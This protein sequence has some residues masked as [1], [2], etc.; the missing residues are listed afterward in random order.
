M[1]VTHRHR[2]QIRLGRLYDDGYRDETSNRPFDA[3]GLTSDS[4]MANA[5]HLVVAGEIRAEE[6][7]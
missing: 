6:F 7:A 5:G 2:G 4:L 3:A 1:T